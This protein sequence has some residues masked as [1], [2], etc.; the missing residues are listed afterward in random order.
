VNAAAAL[1]A[2]AVVL[3]APVARDSLHAQATAAG[4][5]LRPT[6]ADTVGEAGVRV[7]LHRVGADRQGPLDSVLSGPGGRF[8]FRFPSDSGTIYLLSARY[9]GI[10]YFS[11]PLAG[12]RSRPD[13]GIALLVY[14][15]SS[16]APLEIAA[17]HVIIP[18]AGED[19][20]REVIDFV[21][22]RNP[23]RV[24]R[25]AP[26]TLGAS[27]SLPLPPGS[28]GLEVGESDV[29]SESVTRRG[30]TMFVAAPLGP[31][32]KQLSLSY[33]LPAA[34]SAVAVP[35]GGE[36]VG[37]LNILVEEA[38][39]R[40]AGAGIAPADTQVVLGRTFR[41][42]TGP[43]P[44]GGLVR[45]YLPTPG[46]TPTGVLAV[47][48][49]GVALALAAAA[50]RARRSRPRIAPAATV[51]HREALLRRLAELDATYAGRQR[52]VPDNEWRRYVEERARLKTQLE[53]ELAAGGA[54]R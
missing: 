9:R 16:T 18:R 11:P 2:L 43:A 38:G 51:T 54:P 46:R 53:R 30:D 47:L 8:R 10:E 28:D 21:I 41:R 23:G 37:A 20:G 25:V 32:D 36:P 33:H 1:V 17:R 44:A 42:W 45:V 14:D 35:L 12:E 48:V 34:M 29:S 13:T 24:A 49:G 15:T 5:V 31:G 7:V 40:V 26:D 19:G 22:L 3:F 39:A 50:W 4:R 52:D 27:W 6:A